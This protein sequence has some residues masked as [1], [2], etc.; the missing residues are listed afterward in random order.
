MVGTS[1][2]KQEVH[3]TEGTKNRKEVA[4]SF[5]QEVTRPHCILQRLLWLHGGRRPG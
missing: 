3:I 1:V 5:N 4:E 2:K